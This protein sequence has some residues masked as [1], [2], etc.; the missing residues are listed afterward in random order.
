MEAALE[1]PDVFAQL[2]EAVDAGIVE[3]DGGAITFVHPVYRSAIYADASR[4]HRHRVHRR[5]SAVVEDEEQRARHLAL[6]ADGPDA[7]AAASL[8]Q[9]AT[10]ARARGAAIA[11]AEL[12]TL[13]ERLTPPQDGED[14]RRRRRSAAECHLVAGDRALALELLGPLVRDAQP[15]DERAETLLLMGR[16]LVLNEDARSATD[17]LTQALTQE[18]T[19]AVVRASAHA[20]R[21]FA[22]ASRGD[23]RIALHDAEEAVRTVDP[24]EEPEVLADAL[25][26][27]ITAQ[28]WLGRGLDRGPRGTAIEVGTRLAPTSVPRPDLMMVG[29]LARTGEWDEARSLGASLLDDAT[30]A[31]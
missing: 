6:A 10:D 21:S 7:A 27:L 20:W 29:L 15:G 3:S 22:E 28:V 9:A 19:R 8:E 4:A 5:L 11:G 1:R 17:V 16:A 31:G 30:A 26:A 14:L 2:A 24:A 18:G 25:T 12:F 23:L 13:A